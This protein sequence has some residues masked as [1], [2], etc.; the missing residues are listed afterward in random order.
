MKIE[1]GI[2]NFNEPSYSEKT[3]NVRSRR[4]LSRLAISLS[5]ENILLHIQG[6]SKLSRLSCMFTWK[7]IFMTSC[8]FPA[9]QGPSEKV[10]TLRRMN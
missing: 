6:L 7:T 5:Y 8:C 4:I 3:R 1:A 10:S 2:T 9:Y